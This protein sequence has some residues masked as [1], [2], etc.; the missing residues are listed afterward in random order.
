MVGII[1]LKEVK[2]TEIL[3]H[4]LCGN[5]TCFFIIHSFWTYE[6]IIFSQRCTNKFEEPLSQQLKDLV[7]LVKIL[8]HFG[9]AS[10]FWKTNKIPNYCINLFYQGHFNHFEISTG[11]D[12]R[13]ARTKM[14]QI[15]RACFELLDFK[16]DS[17]KISQYNVSL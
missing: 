2:Y 3:D 13:F 15:E 16:Y 11:F 5:E 1:Y 10:E 7:S 12:G 8:R 9:D 4:F 6:N 17:L 14:L